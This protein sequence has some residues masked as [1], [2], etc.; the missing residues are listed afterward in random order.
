MKIDVGDYFYQ[1]LHPRLTT[2]IVSIDES[3]KVNVMTCSWNTPVSEAPPAVAVSIWR[4]SYTYNLIKR[5][6]EFTINIPSSDLIK[7]I[8]ISGF[9]S[10]RKVDKIKYAGLTLKPSRKVNPPIIDKCMGHL[11]CKV[12]NEVEVGE[13]SLFIAE[14]LDAYAV[15][16]LFDKNWVIDKAKPLLHLRYKR[17]IIPEK[18]ASFK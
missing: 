8:L 6:K 3:G 16:E 5:S 9:K 15:K 1:L 17:F 4:K 18:A 12:I 7:P 13:S 14:V 11:E 10:G 2:L